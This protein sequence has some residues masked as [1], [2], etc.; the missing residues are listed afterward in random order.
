MIPDLR[1]ESVKQAVL[2]CKMMDDH[3][4]I[5]IDGIFCLSVNVNRLDKQSTKKMSVS[6]VSRAIL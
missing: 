5:F 6:A 4:K 2:G 3:W 1:Q